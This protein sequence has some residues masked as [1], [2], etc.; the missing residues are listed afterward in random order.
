MIT[1]AAN[2]GSSAQQKG[3]IF[4]WYGLG[5]KF[6]PLH[7][8]R[9]PRYFDLLQIMPIRTVS[10]HACYNDSF[11]TEAVNEVMAKSASKYVFRIQSH[12]G[13]HI[14]CRYSMMSYGIPL[15]ILPVNSDGSVQMTDHEELLARI[16]VVDAAESSSSCPIAEYQES[17]SISS[18][19]EKIDHAVSS[20]P[21]T[22]TTTLPPGPMDVVLGR[23]QRGTKLPGNMLLKRLLEERYETYNNGSRTIKRAACQDIYDLMHQ[24]GCRFLDPAEPN[25]PKSPYGRS[26][27]PE[28]WVELQE[29][30]LALKRIAHKFRNLRQRKQTG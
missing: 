30:A 26:K 28:A 14:K 24:A 29:P 20:V 16:R 27:P 19:G 1:L 9:S 7:K 5:G 2:R 10:I 21:G 3:M 4:I 15:G 18:I 25:E 13:N 23:G 8:G 17:S 11:L 12:C 6:S 22:T